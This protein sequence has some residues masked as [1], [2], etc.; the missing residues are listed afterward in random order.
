MKLQQTS[1]LVVADFEYQM[2]ACF[3]F[4]MWRDILLSFLAFLDAEV[5]IL[6]AQFSILV[7]GE[8]SLDQNWAFGWEPAFLGNKISSKFYFLPQYGS[9]F[10]LSFHFKGWLFMKGLS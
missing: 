2:F 6:V 4:R 8:Q 7:S 5:L 10:D 1:P 3:S 9:S